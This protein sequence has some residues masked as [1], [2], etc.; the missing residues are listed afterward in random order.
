MRNLNSSLWVW[1][2]TKDS[3]TISLIHK[4]KII[5]KFININIT[6]LKENLKVRY[7]TI[8]IKIVIKER[9]SKKGQK[10]VWIIKKGVIYIVFIS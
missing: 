6:N 4:H 8:F 10:D 9:E 7:I 1:I 3:R 5:L 2:P